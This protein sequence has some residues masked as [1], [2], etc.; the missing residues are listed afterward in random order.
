[1]NKQ[2]KEYLISRYNDPDLTDAEKREIQACMEQD[3]EADRMLRQYQALDQGLERLAGKFDL[4]G[5]DFD[6]FASHLQ[7]SLSALPRTAVRSAWRHHWHKIVPLA[8]AALIVLAFTVLVTLQFSQQN[9]SSVIVIDPRKQLSAKASQ[10][11]EIGIVEIGGPQTAKG[12]FLVKSNI[13]VSEPTQIS[14][15]KLM[16]LFPSSLQENREV[17]CGSFGHV[18]RDAQSTQKTSENE[19]LILF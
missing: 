12:D 8:A 3:G 13:E 16:E 9:R 15:A 5:V 10:A 18:P 6:R 1:M 7:D 19:P 14:K 11:V 4:K 17:W 2:E